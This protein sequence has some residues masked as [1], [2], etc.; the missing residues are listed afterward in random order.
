ME[1][2]YPNQVTEKGRPE[3]MRTCSSLLA[4]AGLDSR[5]K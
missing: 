5:F 2:S 3:I 1:K 4:P